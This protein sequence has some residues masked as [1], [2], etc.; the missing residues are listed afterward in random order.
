MESCVKDFLNVKALR[1]EQRACLINL[2]SGKEVFAI[3]P[4]SFRKGWFSNCFFIRK[5]STLNRSRKFDVKHNRGFSISF[6]DE[7]RSKT[8]EKIWIQAAAIGT[9]EECVDD[10]EKVQ[11]GEC[12]IVFGSPESWLSKV[13]MKELKKGKLFRQ[14]A[15]IANDEVHSVTEW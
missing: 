12:E 7:R 9:G 5:C 14:T 4:I 1:M 11:N 15:W 2:A 3:L 10:K 13:W 6:R 8:T